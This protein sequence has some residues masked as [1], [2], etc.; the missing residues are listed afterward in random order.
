[1]EARCPAREGTT[2]C[3]MRRPERD[4]IQGSKASIA[5]NLFRQKK[6]V[7]AQELMPGAVLFEP[8][9][10]LKP[11]SR[12]TGLV[13]DPPHTIVLCTV[14]PGG[15]C[16]DSPISTTHLQVNHLIFRSAQQA[17]SCPQGDS[18]GPLPENWDRH[19]MWTSVRAKYRTAYD[20]VTIP[21]C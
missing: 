21:P 7:P 15:L 10:C 17:K 2:T 3:L 9:T 1:M 4:V 8:G 6:V 18:I 14:L 13:L 11:G 20:R 5:L 12:P 19:G 16:G